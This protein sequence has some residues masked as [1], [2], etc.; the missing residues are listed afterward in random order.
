MGDKMLSKET[1]SHSPAAVALTNQLLDGRK[2]IFA[3]KISC[4]TEEYKDLHI[5]SATVSDSQ[6]IGWRFKFR[7]GKSEGNRFENIHF[8]FV[9]SP[10]TENTS[11]LFIRSEAISI[12]DYDF[13]S[14]R[15]ISE[16]IVRQLNESVNKALAKN[17]SGKLSMRLRIF[18]HILQACDSRE[19]H[20]KFLTLSTQC[21]QAKSSVNKKDKVHLR[22][23]SIPPN[24]SYPLPPNKFADARNSSGKY[25]T[26]L[27]SGSDVPHPAEPSSDFRR[28]NK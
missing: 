26:D 19:S 8:G 3:T 27:K 9:L 18:K 22:A 5:F 6:H 1:A 14:S 4:F 13:E 23:V 11:K 10:G 21:S 2:T 25:W 28:F 20:L 24:F 16:A 12:S 15:E 7:S 17:G